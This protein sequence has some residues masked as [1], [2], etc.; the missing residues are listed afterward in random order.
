MYHFHDISIPKTYLCE[1]SDRKF[2][3]RVPH[4]VYRPRHMRG[5]FHL[6]K[7]KL[8]IVTIKI[9]SYK[10]KL[11]KRFVWFSYT[12]INLNCNPLHISLKVMT[13]AAMTVQVRRSRTLSGTSYVRN[14]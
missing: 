14:G 9:T 10:K 6:K 11:C 1:I 13:V 2:Y 3:Y 4:W 7:E 12:D 8:T 5:G